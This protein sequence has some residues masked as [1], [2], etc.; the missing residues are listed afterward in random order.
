MSPMGL[1]PHDHR[2]VPQVQ[3]VRDKPNPANRR[4]AQRRAWKAVRRRLD[5]PQAR[6]DQNRKKQ[7][8]AM[9][10][11]PRAL[12]EQKKRNQD[13]RRDDWPGPPRREM[14]PLTGQKL[15]A[16]KQQRR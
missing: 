2:P 11:K 8:T 13:E 6:R 15:G 4:P 7:R 10:V 1:K 9:V 14:P 3:P 12:M 5:H 16:R